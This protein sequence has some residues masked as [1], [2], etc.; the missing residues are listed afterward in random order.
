[1]KEEFNEVYSLEGNFAAVNL[2][3]EACCN[4]IF[5]EWIQKKVF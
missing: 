4:V 3:S 2:N 1:M 5:S